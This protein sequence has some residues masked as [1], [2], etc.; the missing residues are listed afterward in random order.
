[1]LT[2]NACAV[3]AA[4]DSV[5]FA[6]GCAAVAAATTPGEGS[7]L[8]AAVTVAECVEFDSFLAGVDVGCSG[9]GADVAGGVLDA[10]GSGTP[11]GTVGS[12][13]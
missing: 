7:V 4:L 12:L 11:T 3:G 5:S 9:S 6:D 2:F 1:M 10:V 13:D 8:V